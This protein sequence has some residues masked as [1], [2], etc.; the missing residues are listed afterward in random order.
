MTFRNNL[1]NGYLSKLGIG[2][3]REE[4]KKLDEINPDGSFREFPMIK[5]PEAA[6][7]R[8]WIR[9]RINIMT[10]AGQNTLDEMTAKGTLTA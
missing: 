7:L 5:A 2:A 8:G 1:V 9:N 4:Q 10:N 6:E 3:L